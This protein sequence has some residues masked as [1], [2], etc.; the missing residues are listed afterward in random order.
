MLC[1]V[2]ERSNRFKRGLNVNHHSSSDECPI[3]ATPV[4]KL[5]GLATNNCTKAFYEFL[6]NVPEIER[7]GFAE[8]F[9]AHRGNSNS[10][11]FSN[12]KKL[13]SG[14]E[15]AK[16]NNSDDTDDEGEAD[17]D[18]DDFEGDGDQG[19]DSYDDSGDGGGEY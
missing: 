8:Q 12:P 17:T 9:Y 6:C 18:P 2:F 5:E 1:G 16:Q 10:K 13:Q 15:H 7:P 19:D 14:H 11:H 3:R 4:T